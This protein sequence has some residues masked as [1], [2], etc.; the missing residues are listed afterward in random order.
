MNCIGKSW[1]LFIWF[2][3]AFFIGIN[4]LSWHGS[5]NYYSFIELKDCTPFSFL[6]LNVARLVLMN[7]YQSALDFLVFQ[8]PNICSN[9]YV[10][11]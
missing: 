11:Q 10:F 7:Q 3:F 1:L 6:F 5:V 9:K 8:F 4:Y 2:P